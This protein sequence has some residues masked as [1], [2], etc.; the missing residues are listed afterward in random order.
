MRREGRKG[1]REG[2]KAGKMKEG[3]ERGEGEKERGRKGGR[4]KGEEEKKEILFSLNL[5]QSIAKTV[6]L[7]SN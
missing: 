3:K 5:S 2:T 7:N 4:G 1:E 6:P